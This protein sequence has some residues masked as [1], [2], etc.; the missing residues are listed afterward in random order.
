MIPTQDSGSV[1]SKLIVM[2]VSTTFVAL[3][4]AAIAMLLYDLRTFQ[5]GW[6]DDLTTQADIIAAVTA[7]AL[8]F[9]DAKAAAENLAVLRV[10]PQ[11][12]AGAVYTAAGVRFASYVQQ[13]AQEL[14]FPVQPGPPGRTLR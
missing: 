5:Q 7:P 6:V 8:T 10:R 9:S 12:V 3:L 14:R 1:R 13:Q 11:I 4:A 2:A